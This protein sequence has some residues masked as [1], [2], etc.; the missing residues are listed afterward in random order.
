MN[1]IDKMRPV[2]TA[3]ATGKMTARQ[4]NTR[5]YDKLMS[6]RSQTL[7]RNFKTVAIHH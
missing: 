5:Q 3:G 2:N 1:G 7:R 6:E 4:E